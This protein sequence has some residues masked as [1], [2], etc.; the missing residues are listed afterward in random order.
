MIAWDLEVFHLNVK[1][2]RI[3]KIMYGGFAVKSQQRAKKSGDLGNFIGLSKF[4]LFD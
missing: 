2:V 3:F 4:L 1:K